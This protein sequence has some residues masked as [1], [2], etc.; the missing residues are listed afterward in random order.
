MA[1]PD[2]SIPEGYQYRLSAS[3]FINHVGKLYTRRVTRADGVEEAWGALRVAAHHVNSWGLC[4]A[5]VMTVLAD[6]GT[7]GPAYSGPEA[8]PVVVVEMSTQ[9]LRAPKLGD[10][11][12]VCGWVVRRTRSLVFTQA[13]GE[14]RGEVVFIASSIQKIVEVGRAG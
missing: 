7:A 6:V 9:F 3:S 1:D 11:V 8:P 14:V 10:L 13:R 2:D 12:E 5:A 4:H